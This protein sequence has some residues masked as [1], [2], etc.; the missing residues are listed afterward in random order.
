MRDIHVRLYG[1]ETPELWMEHGA[2]Y[3]RHLEEL[4]AIDALS[5]LMIIWERERAGTN[6][7][8]YPLDSFERSVGHIF[9]REDSGRYVYINGLMHLLKYSSLNRDGKSLLRGRRHLQTS[10]LLPW[11]GQCPSWDHRTERR[12][13]TLRSI[14]ALAPP[15]CLLTYSHVPSLDPRDPEFAE[16]INSVMLASWQFGCPIE[17]ALLRDKDS[18]REQERTQQASPY[19]IP[20]TYTRAWAEQQD[21]FK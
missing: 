8:G 14:L 19:D 4:C 13:E 2:E 17:Q 6:Y 21:R 5:R 1:L 9:F 18:L 12:S 10:N 15:A 3:R 7:Q 16:K 20:L 11:N